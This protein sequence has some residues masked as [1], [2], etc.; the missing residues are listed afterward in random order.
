MRRTS[1]AWAGNTLIQPSSW[2]GFRGARAPGWVCRWLW[3]SKS[4]RRAGAIERGT[5]AI[6]RGPIWALTRPNHLALDALS[7]LWCSVIRVRTSVLYEELG[8]GPPGSLFEV[9]QCSRH[10]L[11]ACL[12]VG[13]SR[14]PSTPR[15]PTRVEFDVRTDPRF[16]RCLITPR[17]WI[18][19]APDARLW[20][21]SWPSGQAIVTWR[22][23]WPP[24]RSPR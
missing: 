4:F 9:A 24:C 11:P 10:A 18:C 14:P 1:Q 21:R 15:P 8:E 12:G 3:P 6:E 7:D 16:D 23:I 22:H 5:R 17:N 20:R 2:K 13:G 19:G